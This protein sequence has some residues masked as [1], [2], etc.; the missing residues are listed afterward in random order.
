MQGYGQ[1]F[2]LVIPVAAADDDVAEEE[3]E[4]DEDDVVAVAGNVTEAATSG[5]GSSFARFMP[6]LFEGQF[7]YV[8]YAPDP[9]VAAMILSSWKRR[10]ET[11]AKRTL[12]KRR[13]S[14]R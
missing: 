14:T 6:G 1:A 12:P 4:E 7:S 13:C 11:A 10:S 9:R 3:A 5:P 2:E 8:E